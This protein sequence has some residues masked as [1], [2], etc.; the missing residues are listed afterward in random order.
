MVEEEGGALSAE[1]QQEGEESNKEEK[2]EPV[3]TEKQEAEEEVP[4][5]EI[6]ETPVMVS[7]GKQELIDEEKKVIMGSV[8]TFDGKG[9]RLSQTQKVQEEGIVAEDVRAS[10]V[11]A[12]HMQT[13]GAKTIENINLEATPHE[14]PQ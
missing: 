8:D 3:I 14:A 4:T 5:K 10:G 6:E 12:E 1:V 11:F 13:Q 9:S 7:K 2:E